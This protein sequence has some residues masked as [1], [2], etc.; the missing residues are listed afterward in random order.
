[1][2]GLPCRHHYRRLSVLSL[3]LRGAVVF[4]VLLPAAARAAPD[5]NKAE[6]SEMA[7]T[8]EAP[9]TLKPADDDGD[10]K[11]TRAEWGRLMQRFSRL[12]ANHDATVDLSELQAAAK[13][14]D[15]PLFIKL[16]DA[17][18]DGK[19]S[20]PEWTRRPREKRRIRD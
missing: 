14:S 1:M 13:T 3:G 8:A 10:G 15:T 12:D 19:L 16:A 7:A 20:R 6:K 9:A 4:V 2:T 11:V 5:D 18:G 17:D